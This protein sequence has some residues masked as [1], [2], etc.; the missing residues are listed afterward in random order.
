M[1]KREAVLEARLRIGVKQSKG[2]CYKFDTFP[3]LPDRIILLP[4]GRIYLVEM[5]QT[6]GRL[7]VRQK[8][9]HEYLKQLGFPVTTLWTREEV[10]QWLADHATPSTSTKTLP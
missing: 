4:G 8:I 1:A 7:S 6:S 10:D 3:G 5:K 2:A 9:M